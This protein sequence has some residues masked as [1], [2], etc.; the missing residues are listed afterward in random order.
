MLEDLKKQLNELAQQYKTIKASIAQPVAAAKTISAAVGKGGANVPADVKLVQQ[1]LNA[2][3]KSGLAEDGAIGPATINAIS[4]FQKKIFNG[5]ADGKIDAGGTTW[6]KLSGGTTTP[7]NTE[8]KPKEEVKPT[9]TTTPTTTDTP[10]VKL[11]AG[12]NIKKGVGKGQPNEPNDVYK[13]QVLLKNYGIPCPTTGVYDAETEKA[14]GKATSD[15]IISPKGGTIAKLMLKALPPLGKPA[16]V[17]AKTTKRPTIY[18]NDGKVCEQE[19]V[20]AA[21][22]GMTTASPV[23]VLIGGM[24]GHGGKE[25]ISYTPSSLFAKAVIIGAGYADKW[26]H[27]SEQYQAKF[28]VPLSPSK[29]SICGYSAGGIIQDWGEFGSFKRIGLIDPI[30][31]VARAN[32]F[33]NKVIISC[34]FAGWIKGRESAPTVMK[35]AAEKGAFAEE[36]AVGHFSYVQYFLSQFGGD[37]V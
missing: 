25:M 34:N 17:E 21:A 26:S 18:Q 30:I 32:K 7:T 37:L 20:V 29:C 1:L 22:K 14:I 11:S 23:L 33:S 6:Q 27:I 16:D 10:T 3:T 13:V 31:S 9:E 15:F 35:I 36:T 24:H 5:W 12:G 4:A 28:G 19:I 8:T 2:K